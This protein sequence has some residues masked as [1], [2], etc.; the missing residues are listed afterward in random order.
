M[1]Q[2][3][4]NTLM[5]IRI[6]NKVFRNLQQQVDYLTDLANQGVDVVKN[7]KGIV[8]N[9]SQLP[10]VASVAIGTAYAVGTS[11]PYEYY[12]AL[13]GKWVDIGAFP[14]QGPAGDDG[15]DG[16]SIWISNQTGVTADTTIIDIATV[17][18][19]GSLPITAGNLLVAGDVIPLIFSINVV[20]ASQLTVVYRY[21]LGGDIGPTGPTGPQGIKGDK[22]DVGP[23]GPAGAGS[24]DPITD[25]DF[26]FGAEMVTYDTTDG[27]G[28]TANIQATYDSGTTRTINGDIHIPIYPGNN[29]NI[30][31]K[32]DGSGVVISA[33][34]GG[35]GS[36]SVGPTGPQGNIGPTGPKGATGATGAVGPTGPAGGGGGSSEPKWTPIY[37][38]PYTINNQW[39]P[40]EVGILKNKDTEG[41]PYSIVWPST[42]TITSATVY[43]YKT[44]GTES[45]STI[46][47]YTAEITPLA[48]SVDYIKVIWN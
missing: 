39:Y 23:T 3:R 27:I 38:N 26:P 41:I 7:V 9:A 35:G 1:W 37:I 18:N 29:V 13:N 36:G 20:S 33:T 17:Y 24:N 15:K 14:Y 32:S 21:N 47:E 16:N 8:A 46:T 43:Y 2:R 22:G 34:G 12:V 11:K 6:D 4:R 42:A 5:A 19:P 31:A 30:D 28:I 40:Y 10:N 25:I 48:D 45:T 44:D